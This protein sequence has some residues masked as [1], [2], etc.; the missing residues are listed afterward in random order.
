MA[1]SALQLCLGWPATP[2]A[3]PSPTGV[4]A[5]PTL[6]LSGDD[7]LRTPYE[8]TLAI[9]TS[10]SDGQLLRIPDT[11][12]STVTTDLTG[13]ARGAMIEFLTAGQ[14]PA[15]CPGS[16]EPQALPLPP[17][18]LGLLPAAPSPSRVAGKVAS[19]A[20]MT[21]ED[22]F[23][24]TS[25]CGRRAARRLLGRAAKRRR[26]ARVIDV[27]GVALSGTIR[28][29]GSPCHDLRPPDRART[30]RRQLTLHGLTLSGRVGGAPVHTRLAAL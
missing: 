1:E 6:L 7:D 11:G 20:A 10:Y 26:A 22:L 3:P 19:A 12:H 25:F 14:A 8:Q 15:S 9:A 16:S 23:G 2:P 27:P 28:A 17:S 21:I 24:Q 5:V 18:S 29:K 30:T 13:C 4:S